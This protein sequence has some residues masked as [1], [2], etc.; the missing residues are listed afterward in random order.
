MRANDTYSVEDE[1]VRPIRGASMYSQV[2]ERMRRDIEKGVWKPGDLVPTEPQLAKRFGVSAG[3]V[4]Q[5]VL[6]LVREGLLT[7]RSGKGTSVTRLDLSRSF[8]RFFRFREK[9]TGDDLSPI[10]RVIDSRIIKKPTL[11]IAEKLGIPRRQRVL[12]VRR[13]MVHRNVPVCLHVS[14]LP[15]SLVRGLDAED[16]TQS[17]LY[18]I[19]AKKFGVRVIR[20]EELL[21]AIAASKAEA[22]LLEIPVGCPVIMIERIAW[23]YG[24]EV[25]EWRQIFGRS[26]EFRYRTQFR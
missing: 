15:C 21:G 4:K 5:A 19:L 25:I 10:I 3:T 20:A 24:S 2:Y 6:A 16:L 26:D 12:V 9:G 22:R 1:Q 8:S 18:D 13:L 17:G 14:H 11:Q 23:T 7:R